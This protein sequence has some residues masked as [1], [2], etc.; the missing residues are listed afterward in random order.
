[1]KQRIKAMALVEVYLIGNLYPSD[2]GRIGS[3]QG[4]A[5]SNARNG[6]VKR[7][8]A[9]IRQDIMAIVICSAPAG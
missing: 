4:F 7:W 5:S 9:H 6:D 1:V 2:G 3:V 8:I